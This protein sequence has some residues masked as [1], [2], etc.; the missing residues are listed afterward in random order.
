MSAGKEVESPFGYTTSDSSP[1]ISNQI[2]WDYLL[3][4]LVTY[5]SIEGQYLGGWPNPLFP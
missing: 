5:V 2:W 3:W 4:N 1:Y